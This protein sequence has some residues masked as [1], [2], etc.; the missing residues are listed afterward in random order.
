MVVAGPDSKADPAAGADCR[1][2]MH[3]TATVQHDREYLLVK[4]SGPALLTDLC[5]FMDLVATVARYEA[6]RTA[7]FAWVDSLRPFFW[8]DGATYPPDVAALLAEQY[9]G[10]GIARLEEGQDRVLLRSSAT[11]GRSQWPTAAG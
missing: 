2:P 5:G 6:A 11:P 7:V 4:G 3:F 8:R 9:Q 1:D 10:M